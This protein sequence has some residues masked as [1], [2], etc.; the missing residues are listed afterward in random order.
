MISDVRPLLIVMDPLTGLFPEIE[1]RNSEARKSLQKLR[2][3]MRDCGCS[4]IASQHIR[5]PSKEATPPPLETCTN[6]REW[7]LQTRGASALINGTDIRLGVD[8]PRLANGSRSSDDSSEEVALVL[9]GFGRVRGEIPLVYLSRHCGE[10]G[11]PMGY[12]VA[13]GSKLLLNTDREAAFDKLAETF[14]FK[15]AQLAL[16]KGGQATTDFLRQCIG[17]DLIRK[18]NKRYQKIAK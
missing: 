6:V 13:T 10:D 14:R 9:R 15:D 11:E 4:I 8:E 16:G 12:G 7:F 3:V 5:K 1:D 17:L 2:E 18:A